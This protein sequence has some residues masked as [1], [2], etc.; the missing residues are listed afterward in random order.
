MKYQ[1]FFSLEN[2]EKIFKTVISSS[3]DW[4]LRDQVAFR[5]ANGRVGSPESLPIYLEKVY[6]NDPKYWDRS[7]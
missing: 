7:T 4:H 5:G 3:R 1:F 6:F 2:K